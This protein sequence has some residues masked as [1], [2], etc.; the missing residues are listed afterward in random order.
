MWFFTLNS[1]DSTITRGIPNAMKE[2]WMFNTNYG[3]YVRIWERSHATWLTFQEKVQFMLNSTQISNI[4]VGCIKITLKRM[5]RLLH[6]GLV[7]IFWV[8]CLGFFFTLTE[9]TPKQPTRRCVT[10]IIRILGRVLFEEDL[11]VCHW[12]ISRAQE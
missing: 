1:G 6:S 9:K 12:L 10:E 3:K 8:L 2:N 5:L 7:N 4:I 11:E